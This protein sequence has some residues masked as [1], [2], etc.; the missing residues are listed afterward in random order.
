MTADEIIRLLGL[1]PHPKEDGFF[2]ETYR[3]KENCNGH[4]LCTAIYFLL[5]TGGFSEIHRLR[6]DEIFHFYLGSPAE[7][8]LLYSNGEGKI[9]RLGNNLEKAENPQ[10]IVPRGV[11]QGC[12]TTGDFTLFG[13]T[14]APGFE[15]ADYESANR[16]DLIRE[17]PGFAD[18]I[19]MLTHGS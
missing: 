16:E 12:R 9:L 6:A 13:C 2:V 7:M 19:R 17:F 11:W 3:A 15:Y 5:K 1:H 14:V 4:S 10:I 8:L 18:Q